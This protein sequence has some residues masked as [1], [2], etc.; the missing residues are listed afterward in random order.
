VNDLVCA[1]IDGALPRTKG[2]ILRTA[3]TS[4]HVDLVRGLK[5]EIE[6]INGWVVRSA[7]ALG[8]S[9]PLNDMLLREVQV[10][11]R[12][13][14]APADAAGSSQTQARIA[15]VFGSQLKGTKCE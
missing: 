11:E 13:H 10:L 9:A 7:R 14:M 12:L 8:L 15:A 4:L 1:L 6:Q 5:S 3:R 2:D